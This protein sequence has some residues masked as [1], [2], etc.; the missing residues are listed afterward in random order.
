MKRDAISFMFLTIIFLS[1]CSRVDPGLVRVP[2]LEYANSAKEYDLEAIT[3]TTGYIALETNDSCLINIPNKVIRHDGVWYVHSLRLLGCFSEDGN[4]LHTFGKVG[5]GPDEFTMIHDFAVHPKKDMVLVLA[6][7]PISVFYF[8][9]AG[10]FIK[11]VPINENAVNIALQGDNIVLGYDTGSGKEPYSYGIYDMDCQ[12]MATRTNLYPFEYE[13]PPIMFWS[14][15]PTF[16][17]SGS[18]LFVKEIH[19]DT[20]FLVADTISEPVW[21]FDSG[22][23]RYTTEMR[24]TGGIVPLKSLH[25]F[26]YHLYKG[27]VY[28]RYFNQTM[29]RYLTI[30]NVKSGSYSSI[31][32][33]KSA[34]NDFQKA[35]FNGMGVAGDGE[36]YSV[37]Q[38]VK[39]LQFMEEDAGLKEK[40]MQLHPGFNES[41]N[42]VIVTFRLRES[43]L[44]W[45]E[46]TL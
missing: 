36:F 13:T 39:L 3:E 20:V 10:E 28:I 33:D 14:Y 34:K 41:S 27:N 17:V 12:L 6:M 40:I 25:L 45:S 32:I 11:R 46:V 21:L 38:A 24:S 15:P 5:R 30:H 44:E 1:G 29:G 2:I 23:M 19:S 7:S 8:T 4:F 18:E 37:V 22:N 31:S 9:K 26:W 43:A 16:S 35:K 42:P